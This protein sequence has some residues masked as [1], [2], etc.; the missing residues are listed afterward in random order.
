MRS[1]MWLSSYDLVM[2]LK[3]QDITYYNFMIFGNLVMKLKV[4][5][6]TYYNFM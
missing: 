5:D 2:K 3:V 4:Q 6:I 1:N